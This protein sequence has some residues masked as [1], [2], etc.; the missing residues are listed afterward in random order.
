MPSAEPHPLRLAHRGDHRRLPENTLAAMAAAMRVPGCDGVELDVRA[1][2][3][4]IA[5]VNHDQTLAR[6]FGRPERVR[7]LSSA[8]LGAIG[9]PSLAQVLATLPP[10]AFVDVEL[11]EDVVEATIGAIAD[12][13][14]DP[15]AG[16]V[17]SAFEDGILEHAARLAP[18]WPRWLNAIDVEA[19]TI[20]RA[21]GLGCVGI[22]VEWHALDG[23]ALRRAREAG[24]VVAAWTVRRRVTA[25]GSSVSGSP[26][27]AWR[28]RRSIRRLMGGLQRRPDPA[29][30]D[31][32][33][34]VSWPGRSR[35]T[36]RRRPR[37]S[38][39]RR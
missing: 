16:I 17:L 27:S 32:I 36:C 30:G 8:A 20:R 18:A 11:K 2:A 26:P 1:S 13:R 38:A 21:V 31:A 34:S 5:V 39:R 10:A 4:G 7:E 22:A 3:D 23:A 6:V 28:A 24:L 19:A 9:V 37:G 14:G 35:R 29:P 25:D 33:R 12:A 15:P